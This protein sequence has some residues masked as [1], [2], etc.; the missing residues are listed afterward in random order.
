MF[1]K[2]KGYYLFLRLHINKQVEY[3]YR[4]IQRKRITNTNFTIISN[5]CWGGG[6]YEDLG[7]PYRTP[8]VG[9]FF[10]APC[11]LK[12]I[13]NIREYSK[14]N[15]EFIDVSKYDKANKLKSE[16]YY[17]IALLGGDIEIHFLHYKTT[18]EAT[19][20]WNRRRERINFGNLF[21]FFF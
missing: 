5:N 15:L 14:M 20:K 1:N 6:V 3:L 7:L 11:Y 8:T 10:F 9:L 18:E 19:E 21:F 2:V 12:F 4:A 17:P 16:H 13:H